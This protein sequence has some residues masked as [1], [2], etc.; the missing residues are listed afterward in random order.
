MLEVLMLVHL[1]AYSTVTQ[2][3]SS[4]FG[5]RLRYTVRGGTNL[6]DRID[7]SMITH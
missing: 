7:L 6:D 1:D 5:S 4:N 2:R 3:V